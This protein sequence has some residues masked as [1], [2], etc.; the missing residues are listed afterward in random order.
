[1]NSTRY[2]VLGVTWVTSHS[3]IVPITVPDNPAEHGKL[4]SRLAASVK[5]V[6]VLTAC[7]IVF[8]GGMLNVARTFCTLG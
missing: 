1:M 5:G 4:V 2:C 3:E 7:N 6:K 8:D